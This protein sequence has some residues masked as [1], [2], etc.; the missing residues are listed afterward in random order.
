MTQTIYQKLREQIDQYSVGFPE[1]KSGVDLKILQKLYTEEEAALF[2]DLSMQI[3]P[4]NSI[5]DRTHRDLQKT[6][7]MLETMAQNGLLFRKRKAEAVYYAAIPFVIGSFE[8]QLK[9][10]DKDLA[11][12]VEEYFTEAFFKN[13]GSI[14]PPLRTIP[15]NRSVDVAQKVASYADAREIIK[16]KDKIAIADCICRTQQKLLDNSCEKPMEVC[17]SF[18]SHADYY[19]ENKMARLI[20]Q[21]EALA[22]LD[23]CEEAGLV[24]QPANMINPGGMCNCCGDCCGVL[25]ALNKLPRPAEQVTNIYWAEVDSDLCS[26]CELCLDRCQMEA[27]QMS[28]DQIS[29]INT[30]RCIGCGLCVTTCPEEALSLVEKPEDKQYKP[31]KSGMELM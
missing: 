12:M 9:R 13:M 7:D 16:S 18:G 5:A 6:T 31:P 11:Q 15:V 26:G 22:I 2:L 29:V 20:D 19:L 30:D 14:I 3:E 28:D 8:F 23:K 17:F 24:N 10:M 27:V 1:A 25:R 21:E 4:P